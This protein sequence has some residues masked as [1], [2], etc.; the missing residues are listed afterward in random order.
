MCKFCR[1]TGTKNF[2]DA[3]KM[4]E[5]KCKGKRCKYCDK[6]TSEEYLVEHDVVPGNCCGSRCANCEKV[7]SLDFR[8][9]HKVIMF[10]MPNE[11]CQYCKKRKD[12][13]LEVNITQGHKLPKIL[14]NDPNTISKGDVQQQVSNTKRTL[15]SKINTHRVSR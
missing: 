1:Q 8:D 6:K 13:G 10:G 2:R 12:Q 14:R 5:G 3:H 15:G 4:I 7:T 11:R 9:D